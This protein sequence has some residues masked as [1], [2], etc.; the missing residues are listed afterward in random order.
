MKAALLLLMPAAA[1]AWSDGA[2]GLANFRAAGA[3]APANAK[4]TLLKDA[5]ASKGAVCLDGSPGA[6]YH[7]PGTGDGANKWYVHHQG[8]G[9][10][11]SMDDC[12]SRSKGGLGSSAKYPAEANIDGGYFSSDPKQNPLMGG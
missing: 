11:E 7:V 9:W 10:C 3:G 5:A 1:A 6:Y 8:G 2:D 12:L 4:I